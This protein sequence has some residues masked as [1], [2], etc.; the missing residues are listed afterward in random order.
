MPP[1]KSRSQKYFSNDLKG[2]LYAFGDSAAPNEDTIMELEDVLTTYL[3]DVV[4]EANKVRQIHGRGRL[5]AEDIKFAVRRD[6]VKLGRIEDLQAMDR[7]IS[8][9]K[10]MFDEEVEKPPPEKK[11]KPAKVVD[12][13][14]PRRGPGRP[15]KKRD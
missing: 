13:T 14:Q 9:A 11:E 15:R 12:P 10:K 1:K 7:E 3:I 5:R 8:R 6:P 2:L 4:M